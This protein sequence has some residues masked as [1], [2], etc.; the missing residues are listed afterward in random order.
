MTPMTTPER[1]YCTSRVGSMAA[2]LSVLGRQH[3]ITG[4]E[5]R[6]ENDLHVGKWLLRLGVLRKQD[7]GAPLLPVGTFATREVDGAVP[8]LELVT[9]HALYQVRVLVAL[10][11]V[12][13]VGQQDYL[14]IAIKG[15]VHWLL[16]ELLLIRLAEC[17]ATPGEFHGGM[18]VHNVGQI[19][20]L[21]GEVLPVLCSHRQ[22]VR[23]QH[24][25]RRKETDV[26]GLLD[27]QVGWC[28]YA[29]VQDDIRVPV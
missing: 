1:T 18:V 14:S 23:Y 2:G 25:H 22:V 12:Q 29:P 10:G 9:Q 26:V 17:F 13:G 27:N 3:Q 7:G 21:V 5:F 8:P 20:P 15:P 19:V 28:A 4:L 6:W 16:L 24:G 11:R